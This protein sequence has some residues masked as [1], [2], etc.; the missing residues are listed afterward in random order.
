MQLIWDV[1][2]VTIAIESLRN[3]AASKWR[4]K[5]LFF[6]INQ[7]MLIYIALYTVKDFA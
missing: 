4:K 6:S 5:R 2:L 7:S 3:T 1:S